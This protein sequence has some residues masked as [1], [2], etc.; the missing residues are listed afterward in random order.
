MAQDRIPEKGWAAEEGRL[1]V[2]WALG[3]FSLPG[4][5]FRTSPSWQLV[6]RRQGYVKTPT[7]YKYCN[8]HTAHPQEKKTDSAGPVT[9]KPWILLGGLCG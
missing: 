3:C 1:Q 8:D 7:G 5:S 6:L 2:M 9:P 4:R